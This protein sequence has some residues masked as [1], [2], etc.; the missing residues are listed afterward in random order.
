MRDELTTPRVGLFHDRA[1]TKKYAGGKMEELLEQAGKLL[2][3]DV[4]RWAMSDV[5]DALAQVR[6]LSAAVRETEAVLGS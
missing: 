4:S 6:D 5:I 3:T 1:G 2:G